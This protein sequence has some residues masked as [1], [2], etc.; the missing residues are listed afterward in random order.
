MLCNAQGCM[1][2]TL[3][4]M[5]RLHREIGKLGGNVRHGLAKAKARAAEEAKKPK[6]TK[7]DAKDYDRMFE[8]RNKIKRPQV[9]EDPSKKLSNE[10]MSRR[11]E[12]DITE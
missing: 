1:K 8:E 7:K 5:A 12:E 6:V 11:T 9:A 3:P 4:P 2:V 10:E